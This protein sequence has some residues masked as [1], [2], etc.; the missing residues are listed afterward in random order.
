MASGPGHECRWRVPL[1]AARRVVKYL[2]AKDTDAKA[3]RKF[4]KQKG[5]E[6]VEVIDI[7]FGVKHIDQFDND[8][9]VVLRVNKGQ[10][11][12]EPIVLP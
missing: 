4:A 11:D 8:K 7:L 2:G 6:G 12:L 10:L 5:P 9:V 3:T 1:Q